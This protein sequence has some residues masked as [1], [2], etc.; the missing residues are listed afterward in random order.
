MSYTNVND[1][2]PPELVIQEMDKSWMWI[3]F[4]EIFLPS[5]ILILTRSVGLVDHW[6][7]DPSSSI[8]EPVNKQNKK[9]H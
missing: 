9:Y 8:N 6:L 1:F 5:W 2:I 4:V 3:A 7:N